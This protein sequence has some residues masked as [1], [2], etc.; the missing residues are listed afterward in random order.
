MKQPI[1]FVYFDVGGVLLLDYSKTNKW[2]QMKKDL[3]ITQKN[4]KEYEKIWRKYEDKYC[5]DFDVDRLIPMLKKELSLSIPENY[6]MLEDFVNRFDQ[7]PSI[8]PVVEYANKHFKIG[9]LTNVYPKMLDLI[10][11]KNLIPN[12]D[13]DVVIDSSFIGF[14]KPDLEIYKL[15]EDK[16]KVDPSKILFIDNLPG[17]LKI[18]QK[19]NWQSFLYDPANPGESSQKLLNLLAN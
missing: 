6:S 18:P 3:G 8:S 1:E 13:W 9:M 10:Q 15:A 7:N 16:A 5:L 11:Q 19:H 2:Q 4:D 17:H 12:I 14:Q